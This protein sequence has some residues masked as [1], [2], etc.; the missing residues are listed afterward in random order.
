VDS[1]LDTLK[2]MTGG[3]G[4]DACIEAVGM[5]AHGHGVVAAYDRV[6]QATRMESDR[7]IALR[8]AI[9]GCRNGGTVSVAGVFGGFIDK[10]PFGSIMNRSITIK[11]G[12]THVQRYMRPLLE[13]I[14][15]GEIDPSFVVTHTMRLEDAPEGYKIF[16][17]KRDEC[18]K[19]VLKP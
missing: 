6:K 2:E 5:E 14:H 9:L 17:E 15:Q 10:V 7:P 3:R 1:V 19:V 12:Q 4:P 8:Q 16:N 13:R 11:T 18:I